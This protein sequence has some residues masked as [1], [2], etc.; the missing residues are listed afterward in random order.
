[1]I[2]YSESPSALPVFRLVFPEAV[3]AVDGASLGRLEGNLA[4]FSAVGADSFEHFPGFIPVPVTPSA[5]PVVVVGHYYSSI[6]YSRTSFLTYLTTGAELTISEC[7]T[8]ANPAV[9]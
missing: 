4:L 9:D 8:S 1:M 7:L 6:G 5:V 3:P 2:S